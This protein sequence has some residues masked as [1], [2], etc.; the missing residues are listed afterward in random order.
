[1]FLTYL[2]KW[3][4]RIACT[5][6]FIKVVEILIPSGSYKKYINIIT[7]FVV[8][9]VII[10]PLIEFFKKGIEFEEL[11]L[12]SRIATESI[13]G[14]SKGESLDK[15]QKK[16]IIELY[17]ARMK[18]YAKTLLKG[19]NENIENLEFIIEENEESEN[20]GQIKRVLVYTGEKKTGGKE[21]DITI[22]NIRIPEN[23][24]KRDGILQQHIKDRIW[25]G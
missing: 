23:R 11:N 24:M 1:M 19:V 2:S 12:K 9:I 8:V 25:H 22:N 20:Y 17:K 10:T 14:I 15:I 7:G 6:L 18:E 3:I 13:N 4:L 21:V 5:V 16:Q